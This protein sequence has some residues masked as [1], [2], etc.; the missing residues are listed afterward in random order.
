MQKLE[1]S[2]LNDTTDVVFNVEMMPEFLLDEFNYFD[3]I[4][5][6]LQKNCEENW[7]L[8][9]MTTNEVIALENILISLDGNQFFHMASVI[10][11]WCSMIRV[12]D[13][14]NAELEG[15]Y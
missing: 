3:S 5:P 7:L 13:V 12:K 11:M 8:R 10:E 4:L 6:M 1:M 9:E 15:A 14:V 2:L